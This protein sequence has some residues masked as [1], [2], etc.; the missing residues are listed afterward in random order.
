MSTSPTRSTNSEH[1]DA[2]S[3]AG[4]TRIFAALVIVL[5]VLAYTTA[6]VAG[7]IAPSRRLSATHV[8]LLVIAGVAVAVILRPDVLRQIRL[9]KVGTTGLEIER[10][11]EL[12]QQQGELMD[13]QSQVEDVLKEILPLLVP[14]VLA[15]HL[16]ALSARERDPGAGEG[17]DW[18]VTSG[19]EAALRQLRDAHLVEILT[20]N[21]YV[22]E[23]PHGRIDLP[24]YVRLTPRGREW[25]KRLE[26]VQREGSPQ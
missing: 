16:I 21:G 8:A 24:T 1:L 13:K 5:L 20:K 23:I 2:H 26:S 7:A 4:R 9:F 18:D 15:V 6:V 12:Q 19:V 10:I 25:A 11:Q 17:R 14:R 22:S 3:V